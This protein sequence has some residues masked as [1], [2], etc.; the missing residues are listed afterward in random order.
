MEENVEKALVKHE[1]NPLK[2]QHHKDLCYLCLEAPKN[3][4][5]LISAELHKRLIELGIAVS[6]K[7]CNV[8]KRLSYFCFDFTDNKDLN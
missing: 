8:K 7:L 2:K 5:I 3:N 4:L 6:K 1:I